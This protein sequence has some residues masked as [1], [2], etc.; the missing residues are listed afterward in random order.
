MENINLLSLILATLTPIIIGF[1]Y[2][3]KPLFGKVWSSTISMPKK[4][5]VK[6]PLVWNFSIS[7]VVCFLLSLFLL[8]FCNGSGQEGE[9]DT[10]QHGALHG[11]VLGLLVIIPISITG[12]L[13]NE[14]SWTNMLINAGYWLLSLPLMGGILDAMNHF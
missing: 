6:L 4:E 3:Q 8:F 13:Y 5:R 9:F 2:Y 10:F 11:L 14:R 7:F 12:V 1:I